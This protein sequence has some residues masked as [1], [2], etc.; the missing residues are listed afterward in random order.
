MLHV[1]KKICISHVFLSN[2][3]FVAKKTY[4]SSYFIFSSHSFAMVLIENK[5]YKQLGDIFI[6][7]LLNKNKKLLILLF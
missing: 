2:L 3:K 5:V 4:H 7:H 6:T 1:S